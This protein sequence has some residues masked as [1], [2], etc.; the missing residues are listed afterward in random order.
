MY[1]V[2]CFKTH[3]PDSNFRIRKLTDYLVTHIVQIDPAARNN[4]TFKLRCKSAQ[5]VDYMGQAP[6]YGATA[7]FLELDNRFLGLP[8]KFLA[9]SH[10][11]LSQ[12]SQ[13]IINLLDNIS[14]LHR[15]PVNINAATIVLQGFHSV[16]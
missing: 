4:A 5:T 7:E 11:V 9:H 1:E 13:I 16:S 8:L 14:T 2:E 15:T 6:I 3:N 10:H 12:S